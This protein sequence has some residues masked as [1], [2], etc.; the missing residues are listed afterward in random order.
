M[1]PPN[2]PPLGSKYIR[3]VQ[4]GGLLILL[5]SITDVALHPPG[6]A[7]LALTVLVAF[8][9]SYALRIPG[10]V[11]RLSVSEPI[12]FLAT[13]LF[14]PTPGTLTAAVDALVMSLRLPA[15]L[16]TPHRIL[17]NVGALAISLLPS[18]LLY[19]GLAGL[20]IR[21]P[22]YETLGNFVAPLYVFAICVFLINSV[23]VAL[24]VSAERGVSAFAVWR[25]QFLWLSASYLSSAAIAAI[26]V[27]LTN[28]VDI[29]LAGLL[30][31]LV[32]VSFLAVRTTLG[33]LDDT[34]KHLSE[35]NTLYLSTIETLA[36]AIDAKDQVTHGHI[37]RVQR[38]AV[39]LAK[40]LGVSDERQIRAI[41]A[42]ALLH[43]MGKLAIPEFILNK[44][45]R[46]TAREFSVMKTHAAVGADLL[47]SIQFPYPVVPIV[48]H[49]H[50]NWDGSGYPDGLKGADIPIGARI[51]SVVD[52][53][54]AL[55]S[56]RPYRPAMSADDAVEILAQRRGR[57][58]DPLVVD[59]FIRE[60]VAL[61]AE[62]DVPDLQ[63]IILAHHGD[64]GGH[65]GVN[66]DTS[67]HAPPIESLRLLANLSPYPGG[68][69]AQVASKQL[70][71]SL[72]SVANF[73]SAAIFGLD[74]HSSDL[75]VLHA[76]GS[77]AQELIGLRL[78][79]GERLS[80]WVAAH[81]TAVWN[82]DAA[83][84]FAAAAT[85]TRPTLASSVPLCVS[86]SLVGV[87]T[88]YGHS[89]QEISVTGRRSL[90]SLVPAVAHSISQAL[91]R[92]G[93]AIDC[94]DPSTMAAAL[95]ALDVL[96]SHEGRST[97]QSPS[98]LL[99]ISIESSVHD[100]TSSQLLN[101]GVSELAQALSP[102][103]ST[104][105]CVLAF[106]S[107]HLLLCALDDA[108]IDALLLE[109]DDAR[110]ALAVLGL[111]VAA[112]AIKSPLELQNRVR[113]ILTPTQP[114]PSG[115]RPARIH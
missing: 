102:G 7:W 5:F 66:S 94:S 85:S 29:T 72:R 12:V 1:K 92:P 73:D 68:P 99:A 24:A 80:G 115:V 20:S 36:M 108:T 95:A 104:N 31:P 75:R 23:L 50:E 25:H 77:A 3:A 88:L 18:A 43:D 86:E 93:N 33:R 51:L 105:R 28:S 64:T 19:F 30:A 69:A 53:Y 49:H 41:E 37:R 45:G 40:A 6:W 55:T 47:S 79:I 26:L 58:Y 38:Y 98:A 16:R 71:E 4:A 101:I 89:D 60:H 17:F 114:R 57:M 82:S 111:A 10:V 62:V 63:A 9:G 2:P 35:V 96:V 42:A 65:E 109:V 15:R 97:G 27:V 70:V 87:L 61:S 52:C 84:D 78:P 11:V 76:D 48:R 14:G 103:M 113:Q 112:V 13:L 44:P 21:N 107:G 46:L 32:V 110:K 83:L 81:K 56:D 22:T 106:S 100:S 54:D 59:A 8:T 34:N 67:F 39:A 90:E 91:R 74:A